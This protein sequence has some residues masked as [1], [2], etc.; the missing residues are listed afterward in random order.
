MEKTLDEQSSAAKLTSVTLS[1]SAKEF[2]ALKEE[3]SKTPD[4]TKQRPPSAGGDGKITT[5]C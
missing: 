2:A 5:D 4:G 1:A 3:L